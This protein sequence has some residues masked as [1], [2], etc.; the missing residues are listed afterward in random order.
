MRKRQ[1]VIILLLGTLSLV[2]SA[3]SPLAKAFDEFRKYP[4]KEKMTNSWFAKLIV[5][6]LPH[7]E[8]DSAAV[9]KAITDPDPFIRQQASGIYVTI[10][11][12]EP[13]HKQV[14][15]SCT[16]G[17]VAAASDPVDQIRNNSL[18][19]LAMN[20]DG[21]PAQAHDTFV[22]ALTSPN[23]RTAEVAAAGLLKEDN[24]RSTKNHALVEQALA[25]A[26]DSKHK[27]NLL[28]AIGGSGV[29]SDSL[30]QASQGYIFDSDPEIQQ[31]AIDAVAATAT[32]KSKVLTLMQNLED[33]PIVNSQ[34]KRHAQ[35]VIRRIQPAQ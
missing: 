19:A 3:Q 11:L 6:E 4:S 31:A 16:S 18:F 2:A 10:V 1:P 7:I 20:P 32:D 14:A 35:A 17:L 15:L 27:L 12:V 28:Y 13:D 24:G 30:F 25:A 33:S 29:P 23:L 26:P 5:D 9:C 21:P 34:A 8:N 22:N